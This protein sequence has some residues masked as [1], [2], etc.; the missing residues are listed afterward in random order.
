MKVFLPEDAHPYSFCHC[1]AK[2][3][4]S[5]FGIQEFFEH[6]G[7]GSLYGRYLKYSLWVVCILTVALFRSL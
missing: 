6:F 1:S 7:N 2:A 5:L 4:V 3:F